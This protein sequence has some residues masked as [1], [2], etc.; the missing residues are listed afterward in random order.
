MNKTKE[1]ELIE[2]LAAIEHE[3]WADWQKY[4]HSRCAKITGDSLTIPGILV[5]QWERQIKTP[6]KDLTEKEKDS[7]R[8]QVMRYFPLIKKLLKAQREECKWQKEQTLVHC[9]ALCTK[10][11]DGQKQSIIKIVRKIFSDK[12]LNNWQGDDACNCK[13]HKVEEAKKDT[14]KELTNI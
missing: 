9:H 4:M 2:K 10:E 7:D 13:W 5:K 3:R 12:K 8:E 11:K 14:I 6:Y 1:L